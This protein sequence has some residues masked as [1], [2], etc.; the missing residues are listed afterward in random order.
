MTTLMEDDMK[1][2]E[3]ALELINTFVAGDKVKA[4]SLLN[5]NYL[6]H[7]LYYKTER[8]AFIGSVE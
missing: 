7:N 8:D 3:K 4:A 6:Q 2:M 5:E 1:N